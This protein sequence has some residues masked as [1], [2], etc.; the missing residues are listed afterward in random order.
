MIPI[1]LL[2]GVQN[3][4]L[5][6]SLLIMM[7]LPLYTAYGDL[8]SEDRGTWYAISLSAVLWVM[9]IRPLSN[10]FPTQ[11]WLAQLTILRKGVGVL[12]ASIIVSFMMASFMTKGWAYFAAYATPEYWAL[13]PS[14][15]L[16]AH[17]GDVTAVILL[18]TSNNLSKRL[19][20]RNWKRI[21]QLAYVYF[22]C[23][24]LYEL[25]VLKSDLAAFAL[26]LVTFLLPM[27]YLARKIRARESAT[28]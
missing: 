9:V 19:L 16:L 5:G 22:Y 23:G 8:S 17:L 11:R 27:A 28:A 3:V 13:A 2:N 18:I 6:A 21:Q 10:L 14:F 25:I 4:F 1:K 24:A 7:I 12:S 15:T 26:I 20:G